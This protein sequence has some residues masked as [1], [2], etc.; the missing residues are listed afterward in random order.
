VVRS[1]LSGFPLPWPLPAGADTDTDGALATGASAGGANVGCS[2]DAALVSSGCD[3]GRTTGFGR[4]RSLEP[5]GRTVRVE[6][7]WASEPV[8]AATIVGVL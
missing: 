7:R 2:R 8:V 3:A 5:A 1:A 4:L 6:V